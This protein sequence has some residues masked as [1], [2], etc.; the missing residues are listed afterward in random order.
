MKRFP[1]KMVGAL[2]DW[3][4][5]NFTSNT[6]EHM[7]LGILEEI[8][9]LCHAVLKREQGIRSG[10]NPVESQRLIDDAIG[11]ISIAAV[12]LITCKPLGTL[13]LAA[14]LEPIIRM[15]HQLIFAIANGAE[16][17]EANITRLLNAVQDFS[18]SEGGDYIKTVQ[19]TAK[20]VMQR[21]W[22]KDKDNG[23]E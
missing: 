5:K 18:D 15:A 23:G 10:V 17:S 11:D 22:L 4:D 19:Q 21:N 7:M 9:E 14:R 13:S 12:G 2:Q 3:R 6:K 16:P 8:G 20:G 1:V